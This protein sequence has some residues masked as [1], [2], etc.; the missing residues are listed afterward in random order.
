MKSEVK[1]AVSIFKF[2]VEKILI[3]LKKRLYGVKLF[4]FGQ[5]IVGF[6][7]LFLWKKTRKFN[8]VIV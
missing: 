5:K 2:A 8:K 3:G 7:L 4:I 6:F 1:F